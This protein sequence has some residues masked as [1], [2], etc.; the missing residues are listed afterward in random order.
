MRNNWIKVR[1]LLSATLFLLTIFN[2]SAQEKV[3]VYFKFDGSDML[4]DYMA[5]KHSLNMLLH[6]ID[7]IGVNSLDSIVIVS[8]TSPD[9][10]YEHN[11]LL[12]NKRASALKK[13][14]V[15]Q[16][17]E[18]SNLIKTDSRGEAWDELR[19]L[20]LSDNKISDKSRNS[21]IAVI[22]ANI[23]TG[24][25]KWRLEQLPIY[26]YLRI[27][28][29][30]ELRNSNYCLF[31]IKQQEVKEQVQVEK[32]V[33][34]VEPI[35]QQEAIE[36]VKVEPDKTTVTTVEKEE[37]FTVSEISKNEA[38]FIRS[39]LLLPLLNFGIEVPIGTKWSVG[40]DYY[41][42]WQKRDKSNKNCTQVLMWNL[43]GRYWFGKDR[44]KD[45][46]LE[47][48][49]IGLNTM[50]GLYDLEKDYTG[51]QGEFVNFSVD[52]TYGMPIFKDKLHLE[53]TIGL[54]YLFS[55]AEKYNVL[56]EGGKGYKKSYKENIH[57]VG[58][59]KLGVSIVVPI[60][61]KGRSK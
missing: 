52:Y 7:S 34:E 6:K 22:D 2:L 23:N 24:T 60:N 4:V 45:Y 41:F 17:P 28:H 56:E 32:V 27:T 13:Y 31:Y 16:R 29:Y 26:R 43:E 8:Q 57:W 9:G 14:L 38:F 21:V 37:T 48:H 20:V 51:H 44:T 40:A 47:G 35:K 36:E 50:F 58:P 59:N 33:E 55:K 3:K 49:S 1:I 12:S 19:E 39:N 5:N 30:K 11:I 61:I 46:L 42:P 53:F 10:V 15:S 18:T 54:G 25:K